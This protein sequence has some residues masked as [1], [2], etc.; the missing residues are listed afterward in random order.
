MVLDLGVQN[1]GRG[2]EFI[3]ILGGLNGINIPL[4]YEGDLI[5]SNSVFYGI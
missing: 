4:S 1:N 3:F 5:P 2:M